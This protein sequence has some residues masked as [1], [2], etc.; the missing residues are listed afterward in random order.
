MESHELEIHRCEYIE[1]LEKKIEYHKECSDIV[2]TYI[3][4]ECLDLFLQEN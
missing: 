4:Q 2:A 3:T 1:K